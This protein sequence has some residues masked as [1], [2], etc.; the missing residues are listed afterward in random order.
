MRP[1]G[2]IRGRKTGRSYDSLEAARWL[3]SIAFSWD[4]NRLIVPRGGCCVD[5]AST[6]GF[7]PPGT[8]IPSSTVWSH[9]QTR[10]TEALKECLVTKMNSGGIGHKKAPG[11]IT[12]SLRRVTK[13]LHMIGRRCRAGVCL[14]QAGGTG[15]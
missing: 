15:Q 7:E 14:A 6:S 3:R 13:I 8:T 9:T 2:R 10:T 1:F 4:A 11:P 5:G 12:L